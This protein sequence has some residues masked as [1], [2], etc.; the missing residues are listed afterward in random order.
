MLNV[1]NYETEVE[2]D[3][4][5]EF[6]ERSICVRDEMYKVFMEWKNAREYEM[7]FEETENV[8][9]VE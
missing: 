4:F 7:E 1:H 2:C 9:N 3:E 6:C 8:W 5:C